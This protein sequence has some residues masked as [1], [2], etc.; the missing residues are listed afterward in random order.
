MVGKSTSVYEAASAGDAGDSESASESVDLY[1]VG[2]DDL[3]TMVKLLKDIDA[4][5]TNKGI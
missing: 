4:G 3:E 1:S 5:M 2:W